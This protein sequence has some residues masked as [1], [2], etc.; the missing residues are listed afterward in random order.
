[1]HRKQIIQV[2]IS[3][4]FLKKLRI[5]ETREM[6]KISVMIKI[7][8]LKLQIYLTLDFVLLYLNKAALDSRTNQ[9][10][11]KMVPKMFKP[12]KE[13]C[14]MKTKFIVNNHLTEFKKTNEY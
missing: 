1:M 3:K 5:K 6:I 13:Q 8:T 10:I 4:Q 12:V 11:K 9:I 2:K 7:I 14:I